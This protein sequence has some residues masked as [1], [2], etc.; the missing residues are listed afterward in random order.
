MRISWGFSLYLLLY[1]LLWL[2]LTVIGFRT[3]L[4]D[5]GNGDLW[6]A[7]RYFFLAGLFWCVCC[8]VRSVKMRAPK[9]LYDPVSGSLAL[10]GV[11]LILYANL[12]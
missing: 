5:G 8:V 7:G 4:V 10:T 3:F 6:A 2:A 9:D 11:L 1:T 12:A